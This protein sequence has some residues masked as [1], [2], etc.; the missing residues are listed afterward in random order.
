MARHGYGHCWSAP[1]LFATNARASSPTAKIRV[2][3]TPSKGRLGLH[4]RTGPAPIPIS[5]ISCSSHG[6]GPPVIKPTSRRTIH[7]VRNALIREEYE[8]SGSYHHD[9]SINTFPAEILCK[10]F[11]D[12]TEFPYTTL[13]PS[14]LPPH[15][16]NLVL[17]KITAVCKHWR[18]VAL[19]CAILWTKIS[20]STSKMFTLRCARIFLTRSK[21]AEI[22]VYAWDSERTENP[23]ITRAFEE[24]EL[25]EVV[26]AQAHRISACQLSS[27]LPDFWRYWTL[28]APNLRRLLVQGCS[29][30]APPVF[31]GEFPQ[32][33]TLASMCSVIWPLGSYAT[34]THA[35]LLNYNQRSTLTSLLDT[36][37]GCMALEGLILQG[38]VGLGRRDPHLTPISL[39]HLQQIDLIACDSALILKHFEAP[40]L[41]GPVTILDSNLPGDFLPSL[42]AHQHHAPYLQEIMSLV[43]EIKTSSSCHFVSGFRVDGSTAFC[44]GVDG[45]PNRARWGWTHLSFAA[46]ASFA[47]FSNIRSLTL[48]TDALVVPWELWLPNLNS[49]L[50]L[51]VSCPR[52][53]NLVAALLTP[54]GTPLPLLQSLTLRRLG[55]YATLDHSALKTLV[56]HRN[57]AGRPLRQLRFDREEW[58][59][60]QACDE[61]WVFLVESQCKLPWIAHPTKHTDAHQATKGDIVTISLVCEMGLHALISKPYSSCRNKL[62]RVIKSD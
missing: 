39:P 2:R 62:K 21:E 12:A 37:N 49:L 61:T 5:H 20:F 3:C 56:L 50:E 42:P 17:L 31:R 1:D 35:E 38:Y 25:L 32:L 33:K 19:A 58:G 18:L 7:A 54:M 16:A 14:Y 4:L 40:S 36:L 29:T 43:I 11:V 52:L 59:W 8:Y 51:I 27:N 53:D 13:H 55:R 41:R 48:V 46:V 6:V 24:H 15:R 10:V 47:P 28:P 9:R 44:I 57:Q 30:G 34:L 60:I 22:S 26:S 45:A 23:K